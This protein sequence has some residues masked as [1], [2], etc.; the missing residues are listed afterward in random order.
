MID[1]DKI[2]SVYPDGNGGYVL[3]H[4]LS[5]DAALAAYE[6]SQLLAM[7]LPKLRPSAQA[8]V[9]AAVA[10]CVSRGAVA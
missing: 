7:D 9:R 3:P 2:V 10:E 1:A 5:D 6:A 4:E 8:K